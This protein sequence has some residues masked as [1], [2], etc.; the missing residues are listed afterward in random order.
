MSQS[1]AYRWYPKDALTSL[2]VLEMTLEEEGA[3]R[4]ALDLCWL[5]GSL[6]SDPERL[7]KVIGKGASV[8]VARVVLPMFT[9]AEHDPSRITHDRL[10]LERQK[11]REWSEK[12]AKGGKASAGKP[13]KPKEQV[14]QQGGA[15]MVTT[16]VQPNGHIPIA[17]SSAIP[18]LKRLIHEACE[19]F[20]FDSRLIEIAVIETMLNRPDNAEPI[21]SVNYFLPEI[22]KQVAVTRSSATIDAILP[23]RRQQAGLL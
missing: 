8:L 3:Y 15:H 23:R 9:I 20:D 19:K 10:D 6:P 21:Q 16:V 18:D 11:Q 13:K 12:S 5:H 2:R 4:R 1:P 7:A 17:L 22:K 14:E